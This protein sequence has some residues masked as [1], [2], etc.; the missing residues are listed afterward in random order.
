MPNILAVKL[1]CV[2]V[3]S[4]KVIVGNIN[5]KSVYDM[6]NVDSN[7]RIDMLQKRVSVRMEGKGWV[8]SMYVCMH[9][10]EFEYVCSF[11]RCCWLWWKIW[12]CP[13]CECLAVKIIITPIYIPASLWHFHQNPCLS[14]A[15]TLRMFTFFFVVFLATFF[16]TL[17]GLLGLYWLLIQ[18]LPAGQNPGEIY[19]EF[20]RCL[21]VI[22]LL[23]YGQREAVSN[24]SHNN[25]RRQQATN[26]H[27]FQPANAAKRLWPIKWQSCKWL[28]R[29]DI[30]TTPRSQAEVTALYK[31]LVFT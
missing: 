22:C 24:T 16:M 26:Y 14:L 15:G 27:T 5:T 8:E 28:P 21:L 25:N 29:I 2:C 23:Y 4:V 7:C 17:F 12:L 10:C 31:M 9:V 20:P 3:R 30:A 11:Y 6:K 1:V 13:L 19:Q 18:L